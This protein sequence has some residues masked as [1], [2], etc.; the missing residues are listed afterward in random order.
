[1]STLTS[2][3]DGVIA[4]AVSRRPATAEV[5]LLTRVSPCGI[6]DGQSSTGIGSVSSVSIVSIIPPWLSIPIHHVAVE[7]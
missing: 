4:Q 5:R 2:S 7:Q 3:L 1:M 6:C